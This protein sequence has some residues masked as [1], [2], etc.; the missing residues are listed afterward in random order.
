MAVSIQEASRSR[1]FKPIPANRGPVIS[2]PPHHSTSISSRHDNMSRVIK[3]PD[4]TNDGDKHENKKNIANLTEHGLLL[5]G[6]P[7]TLWFA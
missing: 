5:S 4:D 3:S 6:K 2:Q 1:E 7:H